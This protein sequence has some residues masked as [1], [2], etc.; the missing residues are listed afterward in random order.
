[1]KQQESLKD[2]VYQAV[3]NGIFTD[4]YKPN[5]II[6]EQE[7]VQ[8]FGCSKTPVREAL[9]ALCND[10]ILRNFPRFGYQVVSLS[11]DDVA[12]ILDFRFILEGGYLKEHFSAFT[13][14]ELDEL[15]A[16]DVQCRQDTDSIWIALEGKYPVS[17]KIVI[18]FQERYAVAQ[19]ERSM[20]ILK[21]AYAQ[22]YWQTWS[23][24]TAS[25]DIRHHCDII[26]SIE[27]GN[28]EQTLQYLKRD[29]E[30]FCV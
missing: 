20:N 29:L 4:E 15:R 27:A 23:Q 13:Q 21:R 12:K 28:L 18:L 16:I 3:L 17:F 25:M 9:V 7:L 1:M 8:K 30:D 11:R 10:G 6:N 5:Q 14:K 2:I 26:A 19:L 22:F 24:A